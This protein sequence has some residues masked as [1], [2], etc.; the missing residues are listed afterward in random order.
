MRPQKNVRRGFFLWVLYVFLL[1]FIFRSKGEKTMTMML[2]HK[3]ERTE[4]EKSGDGSL[5][6]TLPN[7]GGL[8]GN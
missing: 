5:C 8:P 7:D 6:T 1:T 4:K 2:S 3:L